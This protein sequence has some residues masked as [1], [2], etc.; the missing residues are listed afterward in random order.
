MV[1]KPFH[2]AVRQQTFRLSLVEVSRDP[3]RLETAN[4]VG[5][6]AVQGSIKAEELWPELL[7]KI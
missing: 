5:I 1:A 3:G 6:E 4:T 7:E 2:P